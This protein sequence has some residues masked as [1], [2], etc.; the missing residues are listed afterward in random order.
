MSWFTII[1]HV[2]S[3]TKY[4]RSCYTIKLYVIVHH[5]TTCLDS[6]LYY[7]SCFDIIIYISA[8]ML[9]FLSHY[10]AFF[11]IQWVVLDGESSNT[12]RDTSGVPHC[13]VLGWVVFLVYINNFPKY[14]S[15]QQNKMTLG[16]WKMVFTGSPTWAMVTYAWVLALIIIT[17]TRN[18][19][20]QQ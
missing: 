17:L 5:N 6:P 2:F 19:K 16:T 7:M 8:I 3:H 10:N 13:T 1:L 11:Q 18:C 15:H 12:E 14:L 9:H 20:V 4:Y